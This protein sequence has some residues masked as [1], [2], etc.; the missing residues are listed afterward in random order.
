MDSDFAWTEGPTLW[1][2]IYDSPK[3]AAAG[4]VRLDRLSRRGAVVVVDAATVSWVRGAHRPRIGFPHLGWMTGANR[5]SA[6]GAVLERLLFPEKASPDHVH[7]LAVELRGT[8]L[9]ESFLTQLCEAFEPDSSALLVLS[10]EADLDEVELVIERG[11]ARADVRLLHTFLTDREVRVLE[12]RTHRSAA[13][14]W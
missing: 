8:G 7:D 3:G 14:G 5:G 1:A 9:D 2:W 11:I 12:A 4:R 13:V 10:R 6:L